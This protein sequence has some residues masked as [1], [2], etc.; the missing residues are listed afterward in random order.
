[1]AASGS[2]GRSAGSSTD[3]LATKKQIIWIV[4]LI[5]IAEKRGRMDEYRDWVESKSW[6]HEELGMDELTKGQAG[7]IIGYLQ[8]VTGVGAKTVKDS[9]VTKKVKEQAQQLIEIFAYQYQEGASAECNQG[10]HLKCPYGHQVCAC[11]CHR[12]EEPPF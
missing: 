6:W 7:E 2:K 8:N 3:D 1:M 4:R 10:L 9:G 5:N 11:E 12:A